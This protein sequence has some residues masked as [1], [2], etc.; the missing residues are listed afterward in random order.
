MDHLNL[1]FA[2]ISFILLFFYFRRDD[3]EEAEGSV[4]SPKPLNSFL[5]QFKSEGNFHLSVEDIHL[6]DSD[7]LPGFDFLDPALHTDQWAVGHM[8]F[9]SL[10]V[11]LRY[12]DNVIFINKSIQKLFFVLVDRAVN[13]IHMQ[14][15][16]ETR[17]P[18]YIVDKFRNVIAFD[19]SIYI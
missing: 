18:F 17:K 3:A 11:A 8:D 6:Q 9:A 19:I 7:T 5:Y 10:H 16:I 15:N 1:I 14:D 4:S 13:V 2:C 12:V